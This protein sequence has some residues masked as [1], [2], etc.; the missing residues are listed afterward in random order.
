MMR[1]FTS[2]VPIIRAPVLTLVLSGLLAAASTQAAK[3]EL[4]IKA[5]NPIDKSQK[6]QI[7]TN[8]PA[9][10]TAADVISL[11]GLDLGYDVKTGVYYVHKTLELGPKEIRTFTVEIND[12]WTIPPDQLAMIRKRTE[13]LVA[14]LKGE[15]RTKT[16]AWRQEINKSLDLIESSQAANALKPGE[17]VSAHMKAYEANRGTL[18]RIMEGVGRIENLVIESGQDPGGE[19][20]GEVKGLPIPKHDAEP[21]SVYRT[22]IDRITVNNSKSQT[23]PWKGPVRRD[24]PAEIKLDDILDAGGLD[25]GIDPKRQACYV[26]KDQVEVPA[27]QSV[28]FDVKIRDQWNINMPRVAVVL[29]SASNVLDVVALRG[30]FKSVEDTLRSLMTDL[31]AIEKEAGPTALSDAYVAYYRDQSAR[32]DLIEQKVLRVES[33]LRPKPKSTRIGIPGKPPTMKSTWMI[34][35]IILGF[36]AV[37]SLLFFL[38]WFG[39]TGAEKMDDTTGSG[40]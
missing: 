27:G 18:K 23:E 15:D 33:A 2:C 32:L 29:A 16:E 30:G 17:K 24:L 26:F 38:R 39:R 19:L 22:I 5:G 21:T 13:D 37:M 10:V 1:T 20:I 9:R 3:V 35:Y 34:I 12:I 8:L 40:T 28:S 36:L 14:K 31:R 6:V 25:A 11:D 7:S 4:R